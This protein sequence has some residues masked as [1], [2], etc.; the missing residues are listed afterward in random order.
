M[1]IGQE[2]SI[3]LQAKRSYMAFVFLPDNE[4]QLALEIASHISCGG[5]YRG[6]DLG[7]VLVHQNTLS[8]A[9]LRAI[10]PMRAWATVLPDSNQELRQYAALP[11]DHTV[12]Y[13]CNGYTEH[14]NAWRGECISIISS[15]TN[16]TIME[17][18]NRFEQLPLDSDSND[19]DD[20]ELS[21]DDERMCEG[22]P[23]NPAPRKRRKF[24]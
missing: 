10:H 7:L 16:Q 3:N 9:I 23:N 11:A 1:Q 14:T 4:A 13:R 18:I 20:M 17:C 21:S 22:R 15:G 19:D 5:I 24:G 8:P 2:I 6:L 12:V